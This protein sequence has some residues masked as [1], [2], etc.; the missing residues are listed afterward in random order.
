MLLCCYVIVSCCLFALL[1]YSVAVTHVILN[2]II[3]F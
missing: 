3:I 1:T 2:S